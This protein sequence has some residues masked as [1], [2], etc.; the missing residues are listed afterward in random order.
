M[1]S[2]T[3]AIKANV[4]STSIEQSGDQAQEFNG[5]AESL[6]TP[7]GSLPRRFQDI[8]EKIVLLLVYA[9]FLPPILESVWFQ[10]NLS[11]AL[12]AFGETLVVV[13]VLFR[14]PANQ[15][16]IKTTDWILAFGA[17]FMPMM[18]RPS[19]TEAWLFPLVGVLLMITGILVQIAAKCSLGL[20]F[21]IVPANR[22][23]RTT[24]LYR[25]VRHPIYFGY[26]M[27][28]VGFLW[29][30]FTWWN[31]AVYAIAYSLMIPRLLAEESLLGEDE[32]YQA[33]KQQVR[34]R[35]VPGVF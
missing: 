8:T 3:R 30:S 13:L 20:S 26:F 17:T 33:Y 25:I 32:E 27:T 29:L 15:L 7:T 24:G 5:A 19:G 34:S 35:L 9:C 11:S 23:L 31:A 4:D 2:A 22:G 6:G 10:G 12:V 16:S 21:G 28:H 14:R 18:V 1:A